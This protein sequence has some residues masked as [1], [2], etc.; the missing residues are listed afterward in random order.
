MVQNHEQNHDEKNKQK[1]L[2]HHSSPIVL[3]TSDRDMPPNM[4][5]IR[6]LRLLPTLLNEF[7]VARQADT[8]PPCS[9]IREYCR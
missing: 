6:P 3:A 2:T 8:L 5:L 1:N 4:P 7:L 9:A